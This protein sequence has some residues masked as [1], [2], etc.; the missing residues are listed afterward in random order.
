MREIELRYVELR[1][2][3]ERKLQGTV[4]HYGD[5]A[6]IGG[7]FRERVESG[8]LTVKEDAIL[9]RQHSRTLPL[10]RM[11][12]GLQ[13]H[14]GT[15][16]M[17]LYADL[18]RTT[19]ADDALAMVDAGVLRGFSVEMMVQEDDWRDNA[20]TRIIHRATIHGIALVDTPAYPQSSIEARAAM[21]RDE[22][23]PFWWYW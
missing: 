2:G 6:N 17:T 5:S 16:R 14:D 23:V 11:G 8:A 12:H 22:A 10:A 3:T 15:E 21:L 7:V 18:P 1:R 19:V 13:V 9:N 20:S 4:M